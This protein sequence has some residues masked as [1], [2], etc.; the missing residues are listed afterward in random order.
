MYVITV[1]CF[2]ISFIFIVIGKSFILYFNKENKENYE[3]ID[4]Y[5]IG[6]CISGSLLNIWS[7]FLPT[8]IFSLLFLVSL[9]IG[10]FYLNSSYFLPSFKSGWHQIKKL[11]TFYFIALIGF[12]IILPFAV[13]L[14]LHYDTYLYHINAIQWNEMYSVVPGLANLHDRFGFNSSM[15]VLSAGF[16][17]SAIYNQYIFVIS[18]LSFIVFFIWLLKNI[19]LKK[20]IL[21]I[22]SL[23]FLFYFTKQYSVD[24]SSPATD[25]LPNIFVAYLLISLLFEN[26]AIEK[27]YLVY[28]VIPLFCLTLKLSIFPIAILAIYALI[29]KYKLRI[30]S[31]KIL[32]GLGCLLVLPWL[33]RNV[34]LSGYL[35]YPLGMDFFNF[36]WKVPKENLIQ[37]KDGIYSWARI[38]LRAFNEVLELSFKEWF[39]VWWKATFLKNKFFFILAALAPLVYIIHFFINRKKKKVVSLILTIAYLSFTIWLFTAPDFRFIFSFILFLALFP[40]LI[41]EKVIQRFEKNLNPILIISLFFSLFLISK[42]SYKMFTENFYIKNIGSYIYLPKDVNYIKLTKNIKFNSHFLRTQ[43]HNIIEIFEPNPNFSQCYDQFPCTWY[44]N[45]NIKLR[46]EDLQSGFINISK[47]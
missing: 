37:T 12:L 8:D 11:K 31:F 47:K 42:E 10:L 19:V 6:L 3:I 28:T 21:G 30:Q 9:T 40:I 18:S 1:C 17:F 46:G 45:N 34:I 23:L 22:F 33:V 29:N 39:L 2:I 43:G 44:F 27:K 7:L 4:S 36:D 24:I 20:G 32:F 13:A 35:V 25:L 16:S 41:F 38:P 14:P 15:M 5:C 26:S